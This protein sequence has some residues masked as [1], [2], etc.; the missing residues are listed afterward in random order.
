MSVVKLETRELE[1]CF[2]KQHV[3][4]KTTIICLNNNELKI[5]ILLNDRNQLLGTVTD[6]DIRRG[7][8]N[9]CSMD[10]PAYDIANTT[11]IV[12]SH[13]I[14]TKVAAELMEEKCVLQIP[15][16]DDERKITG[17]MVHESIAK[18]KDVENLAVIMAGGFGK[19]LYPLT[20]D[21]PKPMVSIFGKPMLEHL[22]IRLKSQ[23]FKNF[24]ISVFYLSEVITDYFGDGSQFGVD[25]QYIFED[26]P[27]GTAGCLSL[28]ERDI[29]APF[30]VLNADVQAEVNYRDILEF[31]V[32]SETDAT[33]GVRPFA[34]TVPF[35]V[36]DLKDKFVTSIIEKPE[37]IFMIN[38][39]IY[40]LSPRVFRWLRTN[41]RIDMP[42]LLNLLVENGRNV[43]AYHIY[44][45]WAD[46]GQLE[47]LQDYVD[48][49]S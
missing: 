36:V 17:L 6:G 30:L 48:S 41:S 45:D 37:Q 38:A 3:D 19:R 10:D 39:G 11:P 47:D 43:N 22:I 18:L 27:L 34:N 9:G 40:V 4:L 1:F 21:K 8:L 2:L 46:I 35:G 15:L 29:A 44:E 5:A 14:S 33:M 49:R 32:L 26:V 25:I 16:V 31:N 23:G 24:L 20:K 12:A 28:I 7:L 13:L 42:E